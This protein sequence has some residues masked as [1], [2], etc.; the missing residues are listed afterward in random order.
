MSRNDQFSYEKKPLIKL[1]TAINLISRLSGATI[2]ELEYALG[3]KRNNVYKWIEDINSLGFF[4]DKQNSI[5]NNEV[6]YKLDKKV[7]KG[8]G[9]KLPD[10]PFSQGEV[11]A[12]YLMKSQATTLF[13]SDIEKVID[14]ALKKVS[15]A[16]PDKL[17]KQLSKISSLFLLDKKF[18]SIQKR[19][20]LSIN[21]IH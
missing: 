19:Y 16:V 7:N 3:I 14:N 9:T 8:L 10:I 12:L 20:T 5:G 2:K 18:N 4:I 15:L 17:H 1:I 11:F 21:C 13:G 6:V